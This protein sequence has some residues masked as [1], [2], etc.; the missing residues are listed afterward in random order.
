M[1]WNSCVTL[2]CITDTIKRRQLKQCPMMN[3]LRNK[4]NLVGRALVI[5]SGTKYMYFLHNELFHCSVGKSSPRRLDLGN[6][7]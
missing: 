2:S 3:N 1:L 5:L 7:Q 4:H 6:S